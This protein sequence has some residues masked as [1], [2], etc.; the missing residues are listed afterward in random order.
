M[1]T[2]ARLE[3][4]YVF[5]YTPFIRIHELFQYGRYASNTAMDGFDSTDAA[6]MIVHSADDDVIGIEYGY[7]M[8]Y[9]KYQNNPRFAF[10]RFEDRGHNGIFNDPENTYID[11]FNAE[12]DTWLE[13][14]DYDYNAEDNIER[15]K[16]DKAKYI[17]ESLDHVRWSTRLDEGLFTRFLDFYNDAIR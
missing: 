11:E 7:D 6:V 17:A 14:L 12:F 1:C 2:L 3:E 4:Y 5:A 15:F 8:Y 9:E 13:T 10:I 16:E